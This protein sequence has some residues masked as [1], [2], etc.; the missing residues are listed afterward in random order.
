MSLQYIESQLLYESHPLYMFKDTFI[1]NK[2][3]LS[4]HYICLMFL[5]YLN[6]ARNILI[7]SQLSINLT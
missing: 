4:P 7:I 2:Y 3:I 6:Y 5:Y 1:L